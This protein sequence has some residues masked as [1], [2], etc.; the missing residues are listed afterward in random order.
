MLEEDN[1]P[2]KR[3][4]RRTGRTH[5]EPQKAHSTGEFVVVVQNGDRALL[6]LGSRLA[7]VV[8]E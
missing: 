1:Q 7:T 6:R 4:T 3:K 2:V 8:S 5:S